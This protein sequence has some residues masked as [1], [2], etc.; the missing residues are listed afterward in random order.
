MG[1]VGLSGVYRAYIACLNQQDWS[2]LDR[3]VHD[4]VRRNGQ[5]LGLSGYRAMLEQDFYEIPDLHFDIQLLISD[6]PRIASR[7]AFDCTPKAK[8]LGLDVNGRRVSFTENVFYEFREGTIWQVWSI[9]DK[10]AIEAQL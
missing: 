6:P 7:L 3:F 8:F 5:W 4:D 10:A 2:K 1:E 9:V